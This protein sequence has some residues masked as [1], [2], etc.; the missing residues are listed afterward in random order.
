MEQVSRYRGARCPSGQ[1]AMSIAKSHNQNRLGIHVIIS[2]ISID[3]LC[4]DRWLTIALDGLMLCHV[5]LL[6]QRELL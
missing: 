3:I 2:S 4:E 1:A 6:D 5:G